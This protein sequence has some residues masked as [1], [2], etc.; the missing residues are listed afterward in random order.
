M[1]TRQPGSLGTRDAQDV[2]GIAWFSLWEQNS[3]DYLAA[4]R[5]VDSVLAGHRFRAP[6]GLPQ[7]RAGAA[8]ESGPAF[9]PVWS[10]QVSPS[11][12]WPLFSLPDPDT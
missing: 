12:L 8:N 3:Q 1:A 4:G 9:A 2:P 10:L 5:R 7:P 11:L 6:L